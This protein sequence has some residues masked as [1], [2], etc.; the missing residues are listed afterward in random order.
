M[1]LGRRWLW[2]FLFFCFD[3]LWDGVLEIWRWGWRFGGSW[4]VRV[5]FG[6]LIRVEFLQME[7]VEE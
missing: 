3:G 6:Y 7:D 2:T 1:C 4:M 5:R